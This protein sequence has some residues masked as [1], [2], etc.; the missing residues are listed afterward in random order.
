MLKIE[1]KLLEQEEKDIRYA[2]NYP[3]IK[4]ANK[5][6]NFINY[7]NKNIYE[8]VLSFKDVVSQIISQEKLDIFINLLTEYRITLNRNNIISIPIEFNQFVGL[9]NISY[10]N[11][12]NYDLNSEKEIKLKD[13]FEKEIDYKELLTGLIKVQLTMLSEDYD[14]EIDEEELVNLINSIE[15]YEDQTFYLEEDGLVICFSSYEMGNINTS[16]FE[17]K[18]MYEDGFEYFSYYFI[19]EVLL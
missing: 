5:E 15:I 10:I 3:E 13:I 14:I 12:Y 7:I 1:A 4:L 17:F 18:I 9:Y 6:N 8:D 19:R 2:L 11:S 16:N